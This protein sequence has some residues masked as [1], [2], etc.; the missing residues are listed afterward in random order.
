LLQ[1]LADQQDAVEDVILARERHIKALETARE[2]MEKGLY[3]YEKD[4]S[5][6]LLAEDLNRAQQ[7]LA[8]ITG[9]YDAD[10]LLGEIFTNF[11]IGK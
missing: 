2:C 5:T 1:Q 4:N 7:A 10:D 11:C 3:Q 6:E 9:T 8:E